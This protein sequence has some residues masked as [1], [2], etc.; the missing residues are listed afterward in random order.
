MVSV[1]AT[2]PCMAC[3]SPVSNETTLGGNNIVVS[4][5]TSD[6]IISN[7]TMFQDYYIK[8]Y[9]HQSRSGNC[10][11]IIII[12]EY[13]KSHYKKM[14]FRQNRSSNRFNRGKPNKMNRTRGNIHQ[15]GR[16][17]CTQRFQSK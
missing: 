6:H 4:S 10:E 17:N 12:D 9:D 11:P 7:E 3:T 1:I 14:M 16:T 5:P 8:Y 15:P 2:T 13:H